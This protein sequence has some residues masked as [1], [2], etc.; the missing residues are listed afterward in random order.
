MLLTPP[1]RKLL[2]LSS[3]ASVPPAPFVPLHPFAPAS[4][5][6]PLLRAESPFAIVPS[7]TLPLRAFVSEPRGLNIPRIIPVN[8]RKRNPR[9]FRKREK[10]G[11][12]LSSR[13]CT[14]A[15]ISLLAQFDFK[16]DESSCPY[17]EFR[18][19]QTIL[20]SINLTKS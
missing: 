13:L 1:P 8:V 19:R 11:A 15:R 3:L 18:L 17:V 9:K 16:N 2:V 4:P 5:R 6:A 14:A 10:E 20:A 7:P 12:D